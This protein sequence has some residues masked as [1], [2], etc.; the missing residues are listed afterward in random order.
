MLCLSVCW[1]YF[2]HV[3]QSSVHSSAQINSKCLHLFDSFLL[4]NTNWLYLVLMCDE[5][6]VLML[7]IIIVILVKI[8]SFQDQ[9]D[10]CDT[11][12]ISDYKGAEHTMC[13]FCVSLSLVFIWTILQPAKHYY[14]NS[15]MQQ[16][17]F[18]STTFTAWRV[19]MIVLSG[20]WSSVSSASW[21]C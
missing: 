10:Y 11:E 14:Y 17:I 20:Y 2:N 16:I 6:P 19:I 3:K 21:R 12:K 15:A 4:W 18:F 7:M 13:K 1:V 5:K 9:H 8:F